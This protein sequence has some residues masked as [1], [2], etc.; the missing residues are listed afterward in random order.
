M[1]KLMRCPRENT[2]SEIMYDDLTIIS[3]DMDQEEAAYLFEKYHL[4]SAPVT[5]TTGRLTGMMTVD[6]IIDIIQEENKEDILALAGVN[7]AGLTDTALT[8]VKARAPWLFVNLLTAILA[9]IVI[10][11]FDYAITE[12]VQLAI[13]MPIVASMGGNAGTCLLYTSPS[14]RDL[15]TSRMPSSA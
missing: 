11:F 8:T 3:E 10:S 1:S 14:P 2:L 6:D 4:I 13:L 9:S 15:S 7:E 12:I 5:D